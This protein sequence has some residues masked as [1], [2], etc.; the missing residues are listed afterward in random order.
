[1][2]SLALLSYVSS[3][4]AYFIKITSLRELS[5]VQG[6]K[7]ELYTA[8]GCRSCIA[9]K[10]RFLSF[11]E[12]CRDMKDFTF[13]EIA[14]DSNEPLLRHAQTLGIRV[15]PT[16]VAGDRLMSVSRSTIDTCL[17]DLVDRTS[18]HANDFV[19]EIEPTMYEI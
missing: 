17:H 5:D 18:E 16:I 12:E 1:M 4:A 7:I 3:V 8:K 19:N 10:P 13:C 14:I 15:L 2:K 6:T 11:A 9:V